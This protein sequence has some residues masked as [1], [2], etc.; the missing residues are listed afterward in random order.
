VMGTV[1]AL[2]GYALL[3]GIWH[4]SLVM[5]YH[6]RK[7]ASRSRKSAKDENGTGGA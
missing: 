4:I 6:S 2:T 7:D 1:T 3:A 5:K